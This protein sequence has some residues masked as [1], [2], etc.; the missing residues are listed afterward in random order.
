[1][2]F[3]RLISDRYVSVDMAAHY[4]IDDTTLPQQLYRLIDFHLQILISLCHTDGKRGMTKL[5]R[6]NLKRGI[7][8]QES[9]GRLFIL[10][11][12]I[13]LTLRQCLYGIGA[14]GESLHLRPI[15]LI[16]QGCCE[17]V[18]GGTQLHTYHRPMQ[19]VHMFDNLPSITA[20]RTRELQ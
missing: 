6:Q 1:M 11:H 5:I 8:T 4:T 16:L 2:T 14:F 10:H 7:Q 13:Y 17:D 19:V 20:S 9:L 3:A 18:A 12:T 15:P